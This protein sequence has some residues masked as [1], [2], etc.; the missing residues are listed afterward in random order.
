M[1]FIMLHKIANAITGNS[2]CVHTCLWTPVFYVRFVMT[3]FYELNIN[4]SE[5]TLEEELTIVPQGIRG[6]QQYHKESQ[7]VQKQPHAFC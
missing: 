6:S 7:K 4:R 3:Q 5:N 1:T 2:Y